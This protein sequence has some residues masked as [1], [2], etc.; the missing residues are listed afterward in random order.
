[1]FGVHHLCNIQETRTATDEKPAKKEMVFF[2]T[3]FS[4]SERCCH[5]I[6]TWKSPHIC[7]TLARC[8]NRAVSIGSNF[9]FSMPTSSKED[10]QEQPLVQYY[11]ITTASLQS[12]LVI[13]FP[14]KLELQVHT[15]VI[16]ENYKVSA[17]HGIPDI[18]ITT[19]AID[20]LI[21]CQL[22]H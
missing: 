10:S 16:I 3:G 15:F 18:G 9:H 19:L 6:C 17:Y 8:S 20:F 11:G 14:S 13:G 2:D 4:R 22:F 1:M 21:C 5:L 12:M 7:N